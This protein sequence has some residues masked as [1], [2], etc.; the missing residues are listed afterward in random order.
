MAR[1]RTIKH[2]FFTHELLAECSMEARLLF[3]GLWTIADREG[4]LEDRPKRIKIEVLP[5]DTCDVV[6]LLNELASAG[7]IVRYQVDG[8]AL[9]QILSFAKHQR[10]H[11]KEAASTLPAPNGYTPPEAISDEDGISPEISRP[12]PVVP[13]ASPLENGEWR[14]ENGAHGAGAPVVVSNPPENGE[15]TLSDRLEE[16]FPAL[17][18]V[19]AASRLRDLLENL[20][21]RGWTRER[22]DEWLAWFKQNK[23]NSTLS[24]FNLLNTLSD[25]EAAHNARANPPVNLAEER[26]RRQLAEEREAIKQAATP[27][28]IREV[29]AE[30]KHKRR[31]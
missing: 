18:G 9:I 1:I 2:S 27:D 13:C 20:L 31:G 19:G 16:I 12:A 28:E 29:M 4:R 24:H 26:A 6:P 3:I 8:K 5:Y 7:F 21:K 25:F 15:P 23:R 11:K 17:Q 22:L 30:F 14:M 10:P